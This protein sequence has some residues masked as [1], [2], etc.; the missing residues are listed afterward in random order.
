MSLVSVII[1]VKNGAPTL[2][3]C[4]DSIAVQDWPERETIVADGGTTSL[5]SLI[6]SG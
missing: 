5:M 6:S 4:L 3:H 2:Q 1:G